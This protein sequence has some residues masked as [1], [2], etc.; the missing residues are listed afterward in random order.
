M[1][2]GL[3]QRRAAQYRVG[4]HRERT[5][6][7]SRFHPRRVEASTPRRPGMKRKEKEERNEPLICANLR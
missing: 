1:M 5:R 7:R 4:F 2:R 6:G 3:E